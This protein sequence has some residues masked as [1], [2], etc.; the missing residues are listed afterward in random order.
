MKKTAVL[1]VNLGTPNDYDTKSVRIYLKQFLSDRRVIDEPRWKWLPVLHGIVLRVRPKKSA[2]LYKSIWREEGS[3]LLYYSKKQKDALQNRLK[4]DNIRVSLA[5]TYGNPSIHSEL[6]KLQEWGVQK[7][8]V[9]PLFP[10]YSS[11]TTAPVWDQVTRE[12]QTS[13]GI[14]EMIFIRDFPDQKSFIACLVEDIQHY[15]REEGNPDAL[16]LSYHGIPVR[17]AEEGDDYPKRCMLTTEQIKKHFPKLNIIHCYQSK[18]G[19]DPWLEPNTGETVV[20]L[21]K[22][23][24]RHL[25]IIAPAFTADCLETLEELKTEYA[26]DFFQAGGE[27]YRYISAVNAKPLFIDCLEE[28]VR[29]YL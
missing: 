1:L 23:G 19:N 9:L 8:I 6:Q 24:E 2:E 7:L 13:K 11:T 17:Y 22:K 3:P 29:E 18:F 26:E 4:E 12:L 14:P 20:S 16:V 25:A 15:I 5:M 28:L 10:Q 21:A 27:K